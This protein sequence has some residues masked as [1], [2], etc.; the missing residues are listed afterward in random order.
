MYICIDWEEEE[1]QFVKR[2]WKSK[3]QSL[4]KNRHKTKT[5]VSDLVSSL[6]KDL[7]DA[8]Y[9]NHT[10]FNQVYP[11][12]QHL[13]FIDRRDFNE[14]DPNSVRNR[15]YSKP[16]SVWT[17]DEDKFLTQWWNEKYGKLYHNRVMTK[18]EITQ[19]IEAR[20]RKKNFIRSGGGI[21]DQ[22]DRLNLRQ[23][24][25]K[26][27]RN[28]CQT[29]TKKNNAN[30]NQNKNKRE[31]FQYAK[32]EQEKLSKR[33]SNQSNNN[34]ID[35]SLDSS[36]DDAESS[37]TSFAKNKDT[38]INKRVHSFEISG[39]DSSDVQPAAKRRKLAKQSKQ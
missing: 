17:K 11:Q 23:S 32:K 3:Y 5:T 37:T 1:I 9:R 12:L 15:K 33:H 2:T 16:N 19:E 7:K 8:G 30:K 27:K 26:S 20:L 18:T 29:V 35:L 34:I 10:D 25:P 22:L 38:R 13:N 39:D 36:S 24:R 28:N 6:I 4:Y 31:R 21:W 14:D